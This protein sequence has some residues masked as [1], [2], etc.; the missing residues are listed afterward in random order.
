M[1][2]RGGIRYVLV[3]LLLYFFR[4]FFVYS[5]MNA[6]AF[7]TVSSLAYPNLLGNKRLGCCCTFYCFGSLEAD[8]QSSP[9]VFF[10]VN[11]IVD[12]IVRNV[13]L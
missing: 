13:R 11:F 4:G 2:L 12:G 1:S 5:Q 7:I 8:M 9:S 6:S 3:F 10:F